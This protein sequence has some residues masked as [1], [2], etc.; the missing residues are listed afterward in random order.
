MTLVIISAVILDYL[1]GDPYFF[2]H[3]VRLMGKIINLEESLARKL[4]KSPKALKFFGIIIVFINI[5]L[6]YLP[7]YLLLNYL[8]EYR[9]IHFLLS[10]YLAYTCLAAGSLD[11]EANKVFEALGKSLDQA[12]KRLIFFNTFWQKTRKYPYLV[13]NFVSLSPF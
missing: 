4:F 9:L 8:R 6:A 10:V 5:L 7:A 11:F 13:G 12:R 3:P 1:I 2:P